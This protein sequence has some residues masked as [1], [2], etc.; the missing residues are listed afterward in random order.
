MV[1]DQLSSNHQTDIRTPTVVGWF[2]N[3]K[4]NHILKMVE[5][6][7]EPKENMGLAKE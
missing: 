4:N 5:S 3:H 1:M 7:L 2:I 6:I